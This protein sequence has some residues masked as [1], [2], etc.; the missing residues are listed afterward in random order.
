MT[1]AIRWKVVFHWVPAHC[2]VERNEI[3]DRIGKQAACIVPKQP[4]LL[5]LLSAKKTPRLQ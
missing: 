1:P 4:P 2:G 5:S 3:A